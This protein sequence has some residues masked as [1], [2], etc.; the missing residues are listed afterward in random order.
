[1][2]VNATIPISQMYQ[3]WGE[4]NA[5]T[6]AILTDLETRRLEASS[7]EELQPMYD[8]WNRYHVKTRAIIN[9]I[10]NQEKVVSEERKSLHFEWLKKHQW[11]LLGSLSGAAF[12]SVVAKIFS[13]W[14]LF[15][16]ILGSVSGIII[17]LQLDQKLMEKV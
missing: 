13:C 3:R 10:T 9:S 11:T 15:G 2:T 14:S 8:R 12:F 4:S 5:R 1:M 16:L 17:G 7:T 6:D